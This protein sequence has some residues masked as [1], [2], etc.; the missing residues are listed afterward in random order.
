MAG[1]DG[2]FGTADDRLGMSGTSAVSRIA[3]IVIKGV[4][5][6]T[7]ESSDHFG[8]VAGEIGKCS[9]AG[10]RLPLTR[11]A[12]NDLEGVQLGSSGDVTLRELTSTL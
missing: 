3:S 4:V 2:Y 12:S 11:G 5:T 7:E 6:G 1:D 8:I 10:A 9:V